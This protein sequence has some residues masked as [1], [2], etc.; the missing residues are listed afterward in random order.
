MSTIELTSAHSEAGASLTSSVSKV[1]TA[2]GYLQFG[3]LISGG[4]SG[5]VA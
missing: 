3:I 4:G 2:T 5:R 1:A